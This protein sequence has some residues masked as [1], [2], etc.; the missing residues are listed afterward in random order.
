[1]V[2]GSGPRSRLP[3]DQGLAASR[4]RILCDTTILQKYQP[5]IAGRGYRGPGW[6]STTSQSIKP[7]PISCRAGV[8]VIA[9]GSPCDPPIFNLG[10]PEDE[11]ATV[12][13]RLG[14]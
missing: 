12:S 13:R 10:A 2:L 14:R 8:D 3:L 1:M 5:G 6:V 4:A 9:M 11:P 7:R